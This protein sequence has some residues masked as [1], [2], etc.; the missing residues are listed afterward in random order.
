MVMMSRGSAVYAWTSNGTCTGNQSGIYSE[1]PSD[2]HLDQFNS[3][4][5]FIITRA[6]VIIL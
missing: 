3:Y 2:R 1:W 5:P 4:P 6:F